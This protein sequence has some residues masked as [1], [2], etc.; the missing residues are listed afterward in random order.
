MPIFTSLILFTG[1]GHVWADNPPLGR[2][3]PPQA[4]NSLS[5]QTFP[6]PGQTP[7]PPTATAADGTH[8]TGMHSCF[9]FIFD[10]NWP[11]IV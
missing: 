1:M 7:L 6:R 2:H 5:G 4:D 10:G 3:P 8:P 11:K 9:I